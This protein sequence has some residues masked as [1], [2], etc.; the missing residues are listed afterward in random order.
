M[1]GGQAHPAKVAN[2][3]IKCDNGVIHVID[4]VLLPYEGDVAPVHN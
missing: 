3:D 1:Y 2:M 4:N